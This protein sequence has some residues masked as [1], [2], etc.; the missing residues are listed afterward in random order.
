MKKTIAGFLLIV[1][2]FSLCACADDSGVTELS[3][4]KV[5]D[6]PDWGT[7][8]RGEQLTDA[9][10]TSILT[11]P[12]AEVV[13]DPGL[14]DALYADVLLNEDASLDRVELQ[15]EQLNKSGS[16]MVPTEIISLYPNGLPSDVTFQE[17]CTI[18][19]TPVD[20]RCCKEK[21]A[22]YYTAAFERRAEG[23]NPIGVCA[24]VI[25]TKKQGDVREDCIRRLWELV[26]RLLDPDCILSLDAIYS[27]PDFL[28]QRETALVPF[29]VEKEAAL[30]D[31]AK[32]AV[33]QIRDAASN[34]P[35][36]SAECTASAVMIRAVSP[37]GDQMV[38]EAETVYR[39]ARWVWTG[40]DD[41]YIF[42]DTGVPLWYSGQTVLRP[43]EGKTADCLVGTQSFLLH[44]GADGQWQLAGTGGPFTAQPADGDFIPV[45]W[46]V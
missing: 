35:V 44:R 46:T 2:L 7:A 31:A 43:G 4:R 28:R 37:A 12:G 26:D 45:R 6:A 18:R 17:T 10:R 21:G 32:A 39:P 30:R 24:T 22:S 15:R 9:E 3:F 29:S 27:G 16:Y 14:S 20:A 40:V 1:L 23:E 5:S 25:C 13:L 33:E 41:A 36:I 38:L 34:D 8:A 42:A 19:D 11:G